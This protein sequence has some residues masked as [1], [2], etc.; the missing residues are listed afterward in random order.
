MENAIWRKHLDYRG[1][2][3]LGQSDKHLIIAMKIAANSPQDRIEVRRKTDGQLVW[4]RPFIHS[5]SNVHVS[6][7]YL[8]LQAVDKIIGLSLN[9]GGTAFQAKLPANEL[10]NIS[11][12]NNAWLLQSSKKLI[13]LSLDGGRTLGSFRFREK[14]KAIAVAKDAHHAFLLYADGS[15]GALDLSTLRLKAT[16]KGHKTDALYAGKTQIAGTSE[17]GKAIYI[18]DAKQALKMRKD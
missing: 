10:V 14:P 2:R 11:A 1:A 8:L 3:L 18:F 9:D 13:K 4:V 6:G 17:D 5:F 15:L 16:L 12:L 7:N